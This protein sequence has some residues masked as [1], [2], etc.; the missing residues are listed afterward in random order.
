MLTLARRRRDLGFSQQDLADLVGV[1]RVSIARF[2]RGVRPAT[3]TQTKIAHA[4]EVAADDLWLPE[5]PRYIDGPKLAAWIES[6]RDATNDLD[7]SLARRLRAWRNGSRA[8][9][10][11]V[12]RWLTQLGLDINR[13]PEAFWSP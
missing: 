10:E 2:E 13:V 12:D 11:T 4:L 6:R 7:P 5:E 1:H 9:I 3:A 8:K